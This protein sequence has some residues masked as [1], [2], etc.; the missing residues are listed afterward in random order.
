MVKNV[1]K[2]DRILRIVVALILGILILTGQV[3]GV[4]AIVLGVVA[5]ALIVTSLTGNC[6]FYKICKIDTCKIDPNAKKK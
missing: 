5:A 6:L 2:T 3:A 4:L 1:G